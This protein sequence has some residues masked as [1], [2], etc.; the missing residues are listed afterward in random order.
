[1]HM[2]VSTKPKTI[3]PR[4]LHLDVRVSAA[5]RATMRGRWAESFPQHKLGWAAWVRQVLLGKEE[6]KNG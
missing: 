1:M 5:E 3:T 2:R 6:E 4:T